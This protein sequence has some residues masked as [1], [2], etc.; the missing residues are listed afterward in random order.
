MSESVFGS[1]A[2]TAPFGVVYAGPDE[3]E[4]SPLPTI[5]PTRRVGH[6]FTRTVSKAWDHSIFGKAATAAFYQTLSLPPLLLGLLGTIGYVAVWFGPNTLAILQER[7]IAF[8]RD[9]FSGNVVDQ[10]IAPTVND[11]V[12]NGRAD[13]MSVS[14]LLSLWAGSS[15]TSTFVDAITEA[16]D[17]AEARHPV[18]Q[19]FYAIWLYVLAL[20]VGVF[21]LPIVAVGPD[22]IKGWLPDPWFDV[23]SQL[24]QTLY[25]PVVGLLLIGALTTLYKLALHRSLPWHR[26]LFGAILAGLVFLAA[27][28]LLRIY[29]SWALEE[30]SSY[31]ALATPIAFLLFTFMLGFA[32]VI[33]AEFNATV[34]EFWP[35]KESKMAKAREWLA[36]QVAS[37]SLTIAAVLAETT[38]QTVR[39][40]TGPLRVAAEKARAAGGDDEDEGED[41]ADSDPAGDTGGPESDDEPND[42]RASDSY[43]RLHSGQTGEPGLAARVTGKT[44]PHSATT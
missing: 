35:A 43:M 42:Q 11:V 36:G 5:S 9:V 34:Q 13:I 29:L 16:H 30:G 24:I 1:G 15:A 26:L 3:L 32:V 8:S 27:S 38:V 25:Y 41:G 7:I 14:F 2:K 18:W 22:I 17:Q 10:L 6:V 12:Q 28:K 20:I 4:M 23:G 37:G 21:V 31:G 40:A 39:I 19:R 44:S 33:G